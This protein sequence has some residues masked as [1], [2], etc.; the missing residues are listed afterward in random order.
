[1]LMCLCGTVTVF[2]W[3]GVLVCY[4]VRALVCLC[5]SIFVYSGV[6]MLVLF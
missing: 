5:I 4:C 6:S 1:M 2:V 3:F